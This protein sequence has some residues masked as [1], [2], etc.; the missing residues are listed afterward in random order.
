[1]CFMCALRYCV[2]VRDAKSD[3][4]KCLTINPYQKQSSGKERENWVVGKILSECFFKKSSVGTKI[5]LGHDVRSRNLVGWNESKL[6]FLFFFFSFWLWLFN[7]NFHLAPIGFSLLSLLS[8]LSSLFSPFVWLD[9]L[10]PKKISNTNKTS[11]SVSSS[12]SQREKERTEK[13]KE[14]AAA[15]TIG[16][17]EGKRR[18]ESAFRIARSFVVVVVVVV[19]VVRCEKCFFFKKDTHVMMKII[20]QEQRVKRAKAITS[21]SI[22]ISSVFLVRG[23]HVGQKPVQLLVLSRQSF[24]L[25]G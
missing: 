8:L 2:E 23:A 3:D 1:M 19:V 14:A 20:L 9:F 7:S 10:P 15:A 6:D 17:D 11:S 22:L 18:G 25:R 5:L 16:E 13:K 4:T 12:S 24:V 21:S